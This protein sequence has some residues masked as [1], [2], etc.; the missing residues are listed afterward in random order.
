MAIAAAAWAFNLAVNKHHVLAAVTVGA[1][2]TV[3][4]CG[5]A[6]IALR[7]VW[8]SPNSVRVAPSSLSIHPPRSAE[9]I[10]R[11]IL[12]ALLIAG[13]TGVATWLQHGADLADIIGP[14]TTITHSASRQQ[15]RLI[16]ASVLALLVGAITA[17]RWLGPGSM[18]G[19]LTLTPDGVYCRRAFSGFTIN[20]DD[21]EEI[22]DQYRGRQKHL[23]PIVFR[24]VGGKQKACFMSQFGADAAE[25]YWMIN[26]YHRHPERRIELEGSRAAERLRAQA[27]NHMS[28]S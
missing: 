15:T 4:A 11:L 12:A 28:D 3:M 23:K 14:D 10:I 24:L 19:S 8:P 6:A 17:P 22:D 16:T 1:W 2:A 13:I 5:I 7:T 26:E 20:W 18:T 21:I 27:F 9:V 25:L